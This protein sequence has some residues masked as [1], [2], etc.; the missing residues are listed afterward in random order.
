MYESDFL[1][2]IDL[3]QSAFLLEALRLG[4]FINRDV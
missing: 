1:M 3:N 2:L 4:F